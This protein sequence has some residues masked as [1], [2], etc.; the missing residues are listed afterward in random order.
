[1]MKIWGA[2]SV[3]LVAACS[4]LLVGCGSPSRPGFSDEKAL[5]GTPIGNADSES[6]A[7]GVAAERTVAKAFLVGD[8]DDVGSNADDDDD[9]NTGDDDDSSAGDDDDSS[10]D[11]GDAG[12][13]ECPEEP[14]PVGRCCPTGWTLMASSPDEASFDH[15]ED[16]LICGKT[17]SGEGNFP[18]GENR[19][20]NTSPG[21]CAL[22]PGYSQ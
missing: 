14:P 8:D 4:S 21:T 13:C 9:S 1:M 11:P 7:S 18:S 22:D 6:D 17:V 3:A 12:Q 15:N 19:K 2:S 5:D 20:D 10:S 16:G